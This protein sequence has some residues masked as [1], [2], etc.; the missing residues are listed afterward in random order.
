MCVCVCVCVCIH[1]HTYIYTYIYGKRVK[2]EMLPLGR[3][4]GERREGWKRKPL[5]LIMN[6]L[7]LFDFVNYRHILPSRKLK[8][9]Q[10]RIPHI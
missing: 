1:T 5:Y 8:L 9:K 4:T 3:K 2:T 6:F 10:K 7:V